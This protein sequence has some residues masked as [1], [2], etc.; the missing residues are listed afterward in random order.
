VVAKSLILIGGA[1][2]RLLTPFCSFGRSSACVFGDY[3]NMSWSIPNL[4]GD[5]AASVPIHY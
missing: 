1:E 3:V 4:E 5:P 2:L